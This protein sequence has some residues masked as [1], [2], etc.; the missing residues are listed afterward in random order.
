[1][2]LS[3]K[4]LEN[5]NINRDNMI[6]EEDFQF[7]LALCKRVWPKLDH[8]RYYCINPDVFIAEICKLSGRN[9]Y[10]DIR[11]PIGPK[12]ERYNE[13]VDRFLECDS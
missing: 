3:I 11:R 9:P 10:D 7:V 12:L 13:I 4:A 1:M 8:T 2:C 5:Y 6:D